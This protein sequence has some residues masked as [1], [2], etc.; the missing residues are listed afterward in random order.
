[1]KQVLKTL[2]VLTLVGVFT[3]CSD[4][5]D[6]KP[7]LPTLSINDAAAQEGEAAVFTVT[8]SKVSEKDVTVTYNT[9]NGTA[10][11]ADYQTATNQILTIPAGDLTAEISLSASTDANDEDSET[12][13]VVLSAP[14]NA[15]LSDDIEGTGTINNK[16]FYFLKVKIDGHQWTATQSGFFFAPAF[17]DNS[18]AGYGTGADS[19]SQ[20]SFVF[21]EAPTGAKTFDIEELGASDND[22]VSIYYSPTF[23]SSSGLGQVFNGQ[24][25]GTVVLTKYDVANA[26]AEGTFSFTGKDPDTN[27]TKTFTEGSFRIPIE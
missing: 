23:F 10:T 6:P 8:L 15:E 4:S 24:P 12:F 13:K 27:Q 17:I 11:D 21:Y 25:G 9:V 2:I 26:V 22:H 5:A 16:L 1:M 19:D 14:V 20:L 7:D 3:R 18:F